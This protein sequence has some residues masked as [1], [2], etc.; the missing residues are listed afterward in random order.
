[1]RGT[2]R[3]SDRKEAASQAGSRVQSP[4]T[5][6][7]FWDA[8]WRA[9]N[10]PPHSKG[11]L[12]SAL[13]LSL[14]SRRRGRGAGYIPLIFVTAPSALPLSSCTTMKEEQGLWASRKIVEVKCKDTSEQ[15]Q[16]P[17]MGQESSGARPGQGGRTPP[18][19]EV[20]A[21]VLEGNSHRQGLVGDPGPAARLKMSVSGCRRREGAK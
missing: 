2:K 5:S 6:L 3:S 12:P 19:W 7:C 15:G 11:L 4:P 1:M 18:V 13:S 17:T 10:G 16:F 20:D 14:N 21:N 9:V 8:P